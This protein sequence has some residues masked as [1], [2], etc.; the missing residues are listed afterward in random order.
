MTTQ[1]DNTILKIVPSVALVNVNFAKRPNQKIQ[2]WINLAL[3]K[4]VAYFPETPEIQLYPLQG[5]MMSIKNPDSIK[6]LLNAIASYTVQT[7]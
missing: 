1:L 6:D 7:V 5:T 3:I 4:S 2:R